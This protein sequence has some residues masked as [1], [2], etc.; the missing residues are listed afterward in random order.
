MRRIA[1]A[2][3]V[4]VSVLLGSALAA[5]AQQITPTGPL[6]ATAG[7][8]SLNFTANVYLPTPCAYKLG[9]KIMRGTQVLHDS[10]TAYPKPAGQNSSLTKTAVLN[11]AIYSGD[12]LTFVNSIKV[13][14]VWYAGD[15]W[16]VTV[17]ATRPTKTDDVQKRSTLAIQSVDR[18]RRR[19]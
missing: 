18:D 13:G 11:S 3:S 6:S 19:E 2:L 9:L 5:E 14:T 16:V 4:T 1:I 15:N 7:S 17:T 8:S 12:V 10:E